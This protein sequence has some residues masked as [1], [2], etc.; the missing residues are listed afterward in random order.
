MGE[1]NNSGVTAGAPP[2]PEASPASGPA[3]TGGQGAN[4]GGD[5]STGT[6]PVQAA[7]AVAVAGNESGADAGAEEWQSPITEEELAQAPE[8]W[9]AKF[10]SLLDGYKSLDADHRTLKGQFEPLSKFGDVG[11]IQSQ[12]ELLDG[13]YG[14]AKDADGNTLYDTRTGL[15][16]PSTATF[17]SRLQEGSPALAKQLF[18]DLWRAPGVDG[19]TGAQRMF[20]TLGL[21]PKRLAEYRALTQNPAKSV[22]PSGVAT[23][24]ELAVIPEHHHATYKLLS[25]S[26][27]YKA[28]QMEDPDELENFLAEKQE[29]FENRKFRE[30]YDKALK[31]HAAREAQEFGAS[32]E[33]SYTEYATKLRQDGLGSI[34]QNLSSQIQFSADPTTNAVQTGAVM[35]IMANLLNP[36]LHFAT[37]GALQALGVTLDQGFFDSLATLGDQA[38]AVK[39]YEAYAANPAYAQYR[40]DAALGKARSDVDRLYKGTLAKLSSVALKVAKVIAGGNQELRE[41]EKTKLGDT[42]RPGVAGGSLPGNGAVKPTAKPFTVEWLQQRRAGQ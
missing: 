12:L 9:R 13:L 16:M 39:L 1:E 8:Q 4:N 42:A 31:E 32:V 20:Q 14:Y 25:P 11:E 21:D 17:V 35:A 18:L 28:Q 34:I 15:P 19:L 5:P 24:D 33:R 2:A 41:V 10:T 6:N 29:V 40:N 37:Q 38:R 7:P 3:D 27:R 26:D 22:A 30:D 23:P 36:D